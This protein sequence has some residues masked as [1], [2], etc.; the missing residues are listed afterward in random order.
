[1]MKEMQE[2]GKSAQLL[3]SQELIIIIITKKICENYKN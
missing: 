3:K 1:M 2:P